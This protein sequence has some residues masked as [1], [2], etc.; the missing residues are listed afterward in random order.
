MHRFYLS[1]IL[2]LLF[3]FGACSS[4]TKSTK[5]VNKTSSTS[6]TKK[7]TETTDKA[8]KKV[9]SISDAVLISKPN[10]KEPEKAGQEIFNTL[11][12]Y[13]YEGFRSFFMGPAYRS[14]VERMV[15][16]VKL[17]P[18]QLD[19]SMSVLDNTMNHWSKNDYAAVKM[20]FNNLYRSG[21]K[22]GINWKNA[23]FKD[24][25]KKIV[26]VK[27]FGLTINVFNIYVNFTADG[28]DHQLQLPKSFDLANGIVIADAKM[29]K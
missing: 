4:D 15:R 2:S 26:G 18:K 5:D 9:A 6:V 27:D 25:Q 3:V 17:S 24:V 11:K 19:N 23:E 14:D 28:K 16:S 8:K 22:M 12:N 20:L 21:K 7:V 13:D 29:I 10:L 1:V